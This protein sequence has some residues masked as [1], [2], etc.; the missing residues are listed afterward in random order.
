MS[1]IVCSECYWT[2][3]L[4][5]LDIDANG[6]NVFCPECGC[7]CVDNFVS[8]LEECLEADDIEEIGRDLEDLTD[9]F[10]DGDF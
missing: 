7:S 6:E 8:E 9:L 2:G 5:D 10:E 4:S 1:N 3:D